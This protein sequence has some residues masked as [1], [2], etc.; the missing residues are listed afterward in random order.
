MIPRSIALDLD[1]KGKPEYLV[2]YNPGSGQ[3]IIANH[4]GN[5]FVRAYDQGG[6]SGGGGNGGFNLK[7]PR[8]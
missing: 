1:G 2:I 7:D 8:D 3:V 6:F 4:R 5:D